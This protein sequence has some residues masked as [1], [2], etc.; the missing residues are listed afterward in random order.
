MESNKSQHGKFKK[1]FDRFIDV[2]FALFLYK[3]L[4]DLS[5]DTWKRDFDE[6]KSV[7]VSHTIKT[8]SCL[9]HINT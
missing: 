8:P 7:L 5:V 9:D 6:F 4:L 2:S 3:E 1:G